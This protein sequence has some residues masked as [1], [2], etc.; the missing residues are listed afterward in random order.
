MENRQNIRRKAN[1]YFFLKVTINVFLIILGTFVISMLLQKMQ[2]QS[3][4]QKQKA[5]SETALNEAVETLKKNAEDVEYL[6]RFFHDGNQDTVNDLQVLL[7]GSLFDSLIE[8]DNK[9]RSDAMA[10]MVRRSGIDYLYLVNSEGKVMLSPFQEY[11]QQ[12]LIQRGL[13]TP[14]NLDKLLKGTLQK[15]GS[16]EPVRETNSTGDY[17]SY[18]VPLLYNG[19]DYWL[20]L[21]ADAST[22]NL[23][24]SSL[25]DVSTVL[26][27]A[28]VGNNGFLFAV[29]KNDQSFLY[30]EHGGEVLTGQSALEAGLSNEALQDGYTGIEIIRGVRY[31]CVSK[32]F[33]DSTVVCAVADVDNVYSHDRHVLFWSI[34]GFVMVMLL[35]LIYAV[36]V[37]NDFVRNAVDTKK[38]IFELKNATV[39]FDIS[40]FRK[41]FPLM[42]SGVLVIFCLS[43]YAQTL[44]EISEGIEKSS[45]A[46]EEITAR[47]QESTENQNVIESYYNNRFLSKAKLIA[48]LLEEDPSVLNEDSPKYYSTYDNK[49]IKQYLTDDEGN[50]LKGV[51]NSKSLQNICNKNDLESIYIFDENGRTIAT[52]TG[53]W[54]FSISHNEEDQSYPFLQVL[55]GKAESL[56][57]EATI[58]D[59]GEKAKYIGVGFT[60]Y[61]TKDDNGNTV[62][63]S[64]RNYLSKTND[65]ENENPVTLHRS[66][67]QVGLQSELFDRVLA[68]TDAGYVLSSEMLGGGFFL[69]F[70]TTPD[71]ICLYSP[72]EASIGLTAEELGVSDRAFTGADFYD[73]ASING[74]RYFADFKYIEGYFIATA[75][76]EK[77]MFKARGTIAF[78]TA[79]ASLILIL[80]LSC[81]VTFTTWEEEMLYTTMSEEQP[82]NGL[83][84]A[85]FHIILPSGRTT[86]T[87]KAAARWDNRWMP[88]S[89][90]NPEQK[91]LLLIKIIGGILVLYIMVSVI[92]AQTIFS[93]NSVIQYILSGDWDREP[94]IFA[95]SAC[96]LVMIMVIIG[97]SLVRIPVRIVTSLLGTRSETIG[98]LLLSILKY[99]GAIFSVFYCLYLV[100]MDST[101]L[102]ASAGVLSLV[103]GL[104][105]QSLIKDI[106][107]G[108]FIVFEGEFRVGDI[109][110]I[111]NYRGTVMDIGLRTTKILGADGNIKIYSNSEISGVLNMTKE[112]SLA[113]CTICMEYGQDID[114]VEAVLKRDLPALKEKNPMILTGP[115]YAG[116]SEL[117]DNGIKLLMFCTCN[118]KDIKIVT[119]YMN[120]EVLKIFYNNGINVPFPNVT[121]SQLNTEGRKTM[122]D[123]KDLP[124]QRDS[125]WVKSEIVTVSDED[126]TIDDVLQ[127]T[128]EWGNKKGIANKDSLQLRL[129]AEEMFGIVHEIANDTKT[130]YWLENAGKKY[131]LH[132][133]F[134][135]EMTKEMREHLLSVASSGKNE[136]AKGLIGKLQDMIIARMLPSE[137][138]LNEQ[139]NDK[140]DVLDE[141]DEWSMT[142]FRSDIENNAEGKEEWDELE[143][144]IIA[145][146][147]DDV[148]ISIRRY[149]VEI[150]VLKSFE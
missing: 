28:T 100:G 74:V 42:I 94:N 135:P 37:R 128:E 21:G 78:M 60:Y 56:V 7:T 77:T 29:N 121:I 113:S 50:R 111:N 11:Y 98:H 144:S 41:I 120:K 83:D 15:D 107:A 97:V 46:L 81:T 108:I 4:Q 90:R 143:K 52:N 51:S 40:I 53:N 112:A 10:D 133:L 136:A 23:Q 26:K 13:L 73:F 124:G 110:T 32:D 70:D 141:A 131:E 19:T 22:L 82:N 101:S 6:T 39:I 148:K 72:R 55:D 106:L 76:P 63:L 27:R 96:V 47:Y 49:G 43:F 3:A 68:P 104:G 24:I 116:I 9:T 1:T 85:I 114:Y 62:Y 140:T 57:Q 146:L 138:S 34:T 31:H 75:M 91:L 69:L 93:E 8:E 65:E 20:V 149:D 87:V 79:L 92:S 80:I 59:M 125:E 35:C 58:N 33:G 18:S 36:I 89:E 54:Y 127:L 61:T 17:F 45:V 147:A 117:G 109:V 25:K 67:L 102:L 119:R 139:A 118:E 2:M 30:Y 145:K 14:D 86:S 38:K 150:I 66:M 48:Y 88:W 129:L 103:I 123:Y 105:A 115:T 137:A 126:Q 122:K 95:F 71:H 5:N 99:G 134:R 132:L 64:R 84:S 16:I 142:Q 12:D 44:L 130:H